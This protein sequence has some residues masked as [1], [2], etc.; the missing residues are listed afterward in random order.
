M[1]VLVPA[2]PLLIYN[3]VADYPPQRTIYFHY[4]A[5]VIPFLI[6]AATL[7]LRRIAG[8][9]ALIQRADAALAIRP[10]VASGLGAGIAILVAAT[11]ASWTYQ[12][13]VTSRLPTAS[14]AVKSVSFQTVRSDST[15]AGRILPNDKAIREAVKKAPK[16]KRLWTT[17]NYLP[18][19]SHRPQVG[20]IRSGKNIALDSDA[21]AL[22]LNLKDLRR[23]SCQDYF[24]NLQLANRSGF[25]VTFY[26]D[27]AVLVEKGKGSFVLLENLL[28]DWPG[29]S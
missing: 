28:A 8:K 20:S 1:A 2:V 10:G 23:R 27:G 22:L 4:M 9:T 16:A 13:P 25:G 18:H 6:V 19:L 11:I 15:G 3:Y 7:G 21:E 5:P 12:N 29:C 24:E 26:R 17:S 14:S